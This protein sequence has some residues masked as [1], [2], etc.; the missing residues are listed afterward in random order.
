M[1]GGQ[2]G[3]ELEAIGSEKGGGPELRGTAGRRRGKKDH[4]LFIR[5]HP[6]QGSCMRRRRAMPR[7]L[8]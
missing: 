5:C 3:D 1:E 2:S 8:D 7:F 6:C 4:S